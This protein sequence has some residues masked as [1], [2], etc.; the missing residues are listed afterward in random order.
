MNVNDDDVEND[1]LREDVKEY[2]QKCIWL[3]HVEIFCVS[4]LRIN[5]VTNKKADKLSGKSACFLLYAL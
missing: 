2:E 1:S 5:T 4:F 3:F